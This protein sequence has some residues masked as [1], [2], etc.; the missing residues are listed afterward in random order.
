MKLVKHFSIKSVLEV[1][2]FGFTG[3][4]G[5]NS[6]DFAKN[7]CRVTVLDNHKERTDLIKKVWKE[8]GLTA[9]IEFVK[10]FNK[11]DFSDNAFDFSWNF[12]A[13]W[14]VEDLAKF[15]SELGRVTKK[16]IAIFV[17]NTNGLGYRFQK[18][19]SDDEFNTIIFEENLDADRIEGIMNLNGWKLFSWDYIDCPPW[20]DIGMPKEKLFAK[21][22]INFKRDKTIKEKK[23]LTILDYF[24]GIDKDFYNKMLKYSFVEQYAPNLFKSIWSHHKWMLFLPEEK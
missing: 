4:S 20:P 9:N 17:P 23:P 7:N 13:I 15:L 18:Y 16:L 12:S 5:I 24:K 11:L 2:S 19:S 8:T 22:G 6:M 3:V 21:F 14:F 10:D 1:P